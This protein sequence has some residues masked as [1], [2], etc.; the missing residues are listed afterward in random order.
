MKPRYGEMLAEEIRHT[1]NTDAEADEERAFLMR[2]LAN[3]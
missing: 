2:V 1:V 3:R